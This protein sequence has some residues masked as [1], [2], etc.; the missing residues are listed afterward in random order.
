MSAVPE[1]GCVV[2]TLREGREVVVIET[3]DGPIRVEV[4]RAGSRKTRTVIRAPK[5]L[6]VR[7]EK[8]EQSDEISLKVG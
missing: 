2:V 5:A 6:S 4:S 1:M 7:R 3:P 8:I